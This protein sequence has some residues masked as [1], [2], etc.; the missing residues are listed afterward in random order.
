MPRGQLSKVVDFLCTV[1]SDHDPARETDGELLD[2][3]IQRQDETA[4]EALV[5]RHGPMVLDV[6]RRVLGNVH[7]ADDAFQAAFLVLVRKGS[8]IRPRDQVGNWLYGVAYRTALEARRL[9][10]QRRAREARVLPRVEP[11]EDVWSDLRLRLDEEI[12]GLP[13]KYRA[14]LVLCDLEGKLRKEAAEH[15]QVPE[16][17]VASRLARARSLLARRLTRHGFAVTAAALVPLLAHA[18]VPASL[19]VSTMQSAWFCIPAGKAAA[20]GVLSPRVA[21]LKEGVLKTMFLARLKRLTAMLLVLC[22]VVGAGS[23]LLARVSALEQ[24]EVPKAVDGDADKPAPADGA[25][26]PEAIRRDDKETIQGSW[27][28]VALEIEGKEENDPTA[29]KGKQWIFSA[30][31]IIRKFDVP[32]KGVQ[33]ETSRYKLD[34]TRMPKTFD[35][36]LELGP[37][38]GKWPTRQAIYALEGDVLKIGFGLLP[39]EIKRQDQ[40]VNRRARPFDLG[41]YLAPGRR[42]KELAT[43][44]GSKTML[45]TLK[46]EA[47]D[48]KDKPGK[49]RQ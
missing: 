38:K 42:P 4:F 8:S 23:W 48:N 18:E 12:A 41:D 28:V 27:R 5:R 31:K 9:A 15:L 36:I 20:A 30:D 11:P 44:E 43:R 33:E 40:M 37:D 34:P 7:D 3:Y 21:A 24:A 19:S 45:L 47:A 26:A 6:C 16:G 29:R 46:R 14:V 49:K 25:K 10:A 22:V 17:T 1:A 35:I 2:R 13:D 32:G 39:A